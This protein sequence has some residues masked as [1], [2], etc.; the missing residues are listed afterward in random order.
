VHVPHPWRPGTFWGRW[1]ETMT[2]TTWRCYMCLT[3][4]M[5]TLW[6]DL[7]LHNW[8]T[9]QWS[10]SFNATETCYSLR[11]ILL[12]VNTDVSTTKMCL[13]TSILAK[14]IMGRREYLRWLGD[15]PS[16][17]TFCQL[18]QSKVTTTYYLSTAHG[19]P[20]RSICPSTWVYVSSIMLESG[21]FGPI[22]SI[23]YP[24]YLI[25]P[26]GL[27]SIPCYLFI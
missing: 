16:T 8:Y 10:S 11:S 9:N 1:L 3:M 4:L 15:Q 21:L 22:F 14:S 23:M 5:P 25:Y 26:W 20:G 17:V 27:S 7:M 19:L 2:A 24:V 6:S 13:D 18:M 12:F